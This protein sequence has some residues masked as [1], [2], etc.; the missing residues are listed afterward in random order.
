MEQLNKDN[1][2]ENIRAIAPLDPLIW[3]RE[4]VLKVF[5]F[6]YVWEVYKIPKD[7][8]WGYYVYPLLYYGKFIGRI[9]VKFDKKSKNLKFFN[10]QLEDDFELDNSTENAFISLVNRWKK[11]INAQKIS[12]D[13]SIN[14]ID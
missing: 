4:L 1:F 11:M 2:D 13:K 10:L 7:R 8:R 5:N 6:D 3:D 9:E 14:F 12:K